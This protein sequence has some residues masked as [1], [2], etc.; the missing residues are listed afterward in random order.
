MK[1]AVLAI[2]MIGAVVFILQALSERGRA[3]EKS[4]RNTLYKQKLC[5]FY[6]KIL[7]KTDE[8]ECDFF[9]IFLQKFKNNHL[10]R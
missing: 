7:R 6:T 10:K 1:T 8:K 4:K 2:K 5:R 3:I 9:I